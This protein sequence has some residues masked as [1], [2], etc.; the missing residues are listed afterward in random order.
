MSEAVPEPECVCVLVGETDFVDVGVGVT[1]GLA[2]DVP[3]DCSD[4]VKMPEGSVVAE[5]GSVMLE[6]REVRPVTDAV[7]DGDETA[8]ADDDRILLMDKLGVAE[9]DVDTE[10]LAEILVC[11][12]T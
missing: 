3:V 11:A 1:D 8:V 4:E 10:V 9:V 12:E 2:T 6:L 5:A 7:D